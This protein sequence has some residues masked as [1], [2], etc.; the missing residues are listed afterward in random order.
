MSQ[1]LLA[2][3]L[4]AAAPIQDS[5]K[6]LALAP[7]LQ[8]LL[9]WA[10]PP[11]QCSRNPLTPHELPALLVWAAPLLA[12]L[13]WAVPRQVSHFLRRSRFCRKQPQLQNRI[14][15]HPDELVLAEILESFK[16]QLMGHAGAGVFVGE[17]GS[18][19]AR[20]QHV[21]VLRN[22]HKEA[23]THMDRECFKIITA[24]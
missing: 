6:P 4:G 22:T 7:E 17:N 5:R 14:E 12:L 16:V 21:Y 18:V 2:P 1:E 10:V 9:V 13:V 8:A 3:A 24:V 15:E 20:S 11:L 19:V 23:H